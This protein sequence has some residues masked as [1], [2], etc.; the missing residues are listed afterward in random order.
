[1]PRFTAPHSPHTR[2]RFAALCASTGVCVAIAL[3]LPAFSGAAT[4]TKTFS[5]PSNTGATGI[6]VVPAGVTAINVEAIGGEGGGVPAGGGP[7]GSEFFPTRTGGFGAIVSGELSVTPG[8]TLHIYVAGNG[9][10]ALANG[11]PVNGGANGGGGTGGSVEAGGGAGGGGGASDVR[12]LEAPSSGSQTASLESRLLVAAGGGGASDATNEDTIGDG[13][14][15]AAG[16]AAPS[17]YEGEPAQPG[18]ANPNGTGAGGAGGTSGAEGQPGTLGNGGVA[19]SDCCFQGGGGG[20][21]LYGGGGGGSLYG[22]PG[23]GGSSWVEPSAAHA[24]T[25]IDT[26]GEPRVTISYEGAAP[27]PAPAGNT[28]ASGTLPTASTPAMPP[29]SPRVS[30]LSVLHR[31]V[32]QAALASLQAGDHGLAFSFNL[33]QAANV[34]L[35]VLHRVGSPAWAKCPRPHGHTVS[36]YRSVGTFGALMPAGQ[37]TTSLGSAARARHLGIS[38]QLSRGHHRVDLARIASKHLAPGTYVLAVKATNSAGESSAVQYVKFWV[39]S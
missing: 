16:E 39:F 12:T 35:S 7:F 30:G 20:A 6:F 31:C 25:H 22:Q 23:A 4:V 1:M 32:K 36:N 38:A 27:A 8:E 17:G 9:E 28:P 13:N 10:S 26:T 24:S 21:G 5:S 37:Q 18:T 34:T 3:A 2:Q 14:G 33:S 29:A 19:G 11:E 15:G